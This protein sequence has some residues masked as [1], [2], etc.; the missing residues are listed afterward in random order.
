MDYYTFDIQRAAPVRTATLA[1]V[2][3][4]RSQ[5][6]CA[7]TPVHMIGGIAQ[8][9]STAQVREFVRAVHDADCVG[10]SLY[11]WAGTSHSE[12]QQLAGVKAT[13]SR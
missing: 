7:S 3:I 11:G 2:R 10:G 12:W 13:S 8:D 9:S 6:G 1:D 4:L 5:P